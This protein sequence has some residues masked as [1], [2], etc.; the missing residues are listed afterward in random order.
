[1]DK[2]ALR[3]AILAA[4]E[5]ELVTLVS[6]AESAHAEATDDENRSEG[7]YDMRAQLA[8]YVAAGQAKLAGEV[9]EAIATYTSLVLPNFA[10]TDIIALG[11]VVTLSNGRNK[12][13]YLLGPSRGGLEISCEEKSVIVV[14]PIS[15]LGRQLL[16][17]RSGTK[18]TLPGQRQEQTIVSVE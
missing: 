6:A 17:K 10:A 8:A 14:T 5:Q 15:P 3:S 16:G 11:A 4:L 13:H 18:L 7:K 1:M 9:G 12:L 2:A